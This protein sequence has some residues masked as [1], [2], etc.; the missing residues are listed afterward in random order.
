MVNGDRGLYEHNSTS[1]STFLRGIVVDR[2]DPLMEGRIA[3]TIPRLI[4][5]G[6]PAGLTLK[7]KTTNVNTD[8]LENPEVGEL[9][10][11]SVETSN[12]LWAR[13]TKKTS[14]RYHVPYLGQTVY[15]FM[16]DGDPSKIYYMDFF[17]TIQGDNPEMYYVQAVSDVYTPDKKPNIHLLHEFLDRC[18][19]YYNEN[20]E[21]RE[22]R[23]H[24]PNNSYITILENDTDTKIE[25]Q[26]PSKH[27]IAMDD[28]AAKISVLTS[29]GHSIILD[30]GGG[31]T[32]PKEGE[33]GTSSKNKSSGSEKGG[34]KGGGGI[35][36]K[37]VGGSTITMTGDGTQINLKNNA[38]AETDMKGAVIT[39][40][41][42][43][44]KVVI[45]NNKITSTASGGKIVI[46]NGKVMLN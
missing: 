33:E 41:A 32:K 1:T 13:P 14:G 17:P 20:K 25:L 26:T 21:T 40:T 3:V 35:F 22:Y 30:D 8:F 4:H 15:I 45:G 10:N 24:L 9:V 7:T 11:G 38:G 2:E 18:A 27:T 46:G 29:K 42:G 43:G 19:V 12:A 36:A 6:D 31:K 37:T 23:I 44:G 34:E 39:S 5:E 16:E 28:V